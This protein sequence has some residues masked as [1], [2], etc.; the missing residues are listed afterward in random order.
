MRDFGLDIIREDEDD[1]SKAPLSYNNTLNI[2]PNKEIKYYDVSHKYF[3]GVDLQLDKRLDYSITVEYLEKK[4]SNKLHHWRVDKKKIF[5]NQKEPSLVVE[6]ISVK[7]IK[8]IYPINIATDYSGKIISITNHEEILGRWLDSKEKLILE[9]K[10]ELV[11]KLLRKFER[12]IQDLTKLELSLTK[13]IFWAS[14][15]SK[16]YLEYGSSCKKSIDF[17]FP[18]EAYETPIVYKGFMELSPLLTEHEAIELNYK[19]V[20]EIPALSKLYHKREQHRLTSDL[21]IKYYLE[22][23]TKIPT[24]INVIFDVYDETRKEDIS[25]TEIS[26]T[27]DELGNNNNTN[28]SAVEEQT[29]SENNNEIPKKKKKWFSFGF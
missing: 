21:E 1:V 22:A 25:L 8:V 28:Q 19:G 13:E 11:Y 3:N 26:I 18:L 14:F 6:E 27:L 29:S 9:Y 16:R 15:F 23:T 24:S 4:I 2:A 20:S 17:L 7:L 10:G 5:F 12:L